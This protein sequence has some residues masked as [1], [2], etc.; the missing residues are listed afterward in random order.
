[1]T[2]FFELSKSELALT[3]AGKSRED[4]VA[5]YLNANKQVKE[6]LKKAGID[7]DEIFDRPKTQEM[8]KE[9][10]ERLLSDRKILP[11]LMGLNIHLDAE[12]D[13]RLRH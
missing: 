5:E 1:M 2:G 10:A 6:T 7:L 4:Y 12:I 8:R 11:L 3:V 13:K 9:F